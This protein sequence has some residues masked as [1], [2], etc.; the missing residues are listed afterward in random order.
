MTT[1]EAPEAAPD[2]PPGFARGRRR[3]PREWAVAVMERATERLR[4]EFASGE[5]KGPF[6]LVQRFLGF[7][8]PPSYADAARSA[9]MSIVQLK[10]LLHRARS[11]FRELVREE[12][13]DT[14]G[15]DPDAEVGELL[16]ALRP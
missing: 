16:R 5:R 6:D 14:S 9:G 15:G 1:A 11:R 3:L 12:V 10:A 4:R 8:E 13:S 7:A 2:G